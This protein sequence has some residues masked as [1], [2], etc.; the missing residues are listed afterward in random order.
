M[1]SKISS[2]NISSRVVIKSLAIFIPKFEVIIA[3]YDGDHVT[4]TDWVIFYSHHSFDADNICD[5]NLVHF[6]IFSE[7]RGVSQISWAVCPLQRKPSTTPNKKTAKQFCCDYMFALR[8]KIEIIR[9]ILDA[10]KYSWIRNYI[11]PIPTNHCSLCH[12][13]VPEYLLH[14]F[15]FITITVTLLD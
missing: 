2:W 8:I 11:V 1:G 15:L 6:V 14:Y 9:P 10:A 12:A 13:Y 5:E 7:K 4:I 3:N